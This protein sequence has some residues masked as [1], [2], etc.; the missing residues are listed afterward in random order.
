MSLR[1]NE[2]AGKR[3]GILIWGDDGAGEEGNDTGSTIRGRRTAAGAGSDDSEKGGEGAYGE[4]SG[5]QEMSVQE[6]MQSFGGG[7]LDGDLPRRSNKSQREPSAATSAGGS[8]VKRGTRRMRARGTIKRNS[9]FFDATLPN[10]LVD[11]SASEGTLDEARQD[12]DVAAPTSPSTLPTT[13]PLDA[14]LLDEPPPMMAGVVEEE[15][16]G[17]SEDDEDDPNLLDLPASPL[18]ALSL[19][20][21]S[22]ES[23]FGELSFEGGVDLC[24]EVEDLGGGWSLGF[25]KSAGEQGRGLI[26]RGWYAYVDKPKPLDDETEA[27]ETHERP[28][29]EASATFSIATSDPTIALFFPVVLEASETTS[30]ADP[31][32]AVSSPLNASSPPAHATSSPPLVAPSLPSTPSTPGDRVSIHPSKPVLSP[33]TPPSNTTSLNP[34]NASL[35]P[36][37]PLSLPPPF[38]P[39]SSALPVRSPTPPSPSPTQ[40]RSPNFP[41]PTPPSPISQP[42]T[43]LLALPSFPQTPISPTASES[44]VSEV[45]ESPSVIRARSIGRHVIISGIEFEPT[46]SE[47]AL[48]EESEEV[49]QEG[50]LSLTEA[51]E[52]AGERIPFDGTRPFGEVAEVENFSRVHRSGEEIDEHAEAEEGR[53]ERWAKAVQDAD[54]RASGHDGRFDVFEP[55]GAKVGSE[56]HDV[57]L[58]ESLFEEQG[59]YREESY[60][61]AEDVD[62][63][64]DLPRRMEVV[65]PRYLTSTE[66][67]PSPTP[68]PSSFFDL[69]GLGTIGRSGSAGSMIGVKGA[70]GRVGSSVGASERVKGNVSVEEWVLNGDESHEEEGERRWHIESGPAWLSDSEAFVVHV[71][72]PCKRS[73]YNNRAYT[74][75]T[76]TTVF[77]SGEDPITVERRYSHFVQLHALLSSRYPLIVIPPL[78][79]KT[80]AGRFEDGFVE[81]RRRD[82]ERW[83]GRVGRHPVLR[84]SDEIKEFL[85]L[86]GD[87]DLKRLLN[88]PKDD[89]TQGFFGRV[90]HPA[91]NVDAADAEELGEIFDSHTRAVELGGGFKTVEE[92]VF[93]LR[94]GL[95]DTAGTLKTLAH[96]LARLV[97]GLALPP[98]TAA[99]QDDNDVEPPERERRRARALGLQNE[100]GAMTWKYGCEESLSTAKALQATAES[101]ASVADLVDTHARD[102]LL[103]TQELLREISYPSSQHAA[104]IQ[105]HKSAL[106]LHKQLTASDANDEEAVSRCDTIINITSAELERAHAERNEDM[107]MVAEQYLDGE[108]AFHEQALAK[109][110]FARSHFEPSAFASLALTGPRLR[111]TLER[112]S[113]SFPNLPVPSSYGMP[114]STLGVGS[115]IGRPGAVVSEVIGS[116]L[117]RSTTPVVHAYAERA[118]ATSGTMGRSAAEILAEA[119]HSRPPPGQAT[120]RSSIF[121]TPKLW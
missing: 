61:E 96:H 106:A 38:I 33:E 78:P 82:L 118:S 64:P 46:E 86:E 110:R 100:D 9:I 12:V 8:T 20:P 58:N 44:N 87:Q 23:A 68:R 36:F 91:F 18:L 69:I 45:S 120:W 37:S 73:S 32:P 109:L 19:H 7:E 77:A 85:S 27:A 41:L 11:P 89:A 40:T 102:A 104:L 101:I 42:S 39:A 52:A 13:S 114:L 24:V 65:P 93:K 4:T 81:S 2:E 115:S 92:D 66:E 49:E 90:F 53:E 83:S 28:T 71:H 95:R 29:S 48:M 15:A 108:I 76:L 97:A 63:V 72:S 22:G 75:F 26:P 1:R 99:E 60:P 74:S 56:E 21:F 50:E 10:P 62:Q 80:Y 35:F 98:V 88:P 34:P 55:E 84:S 17:G 107:R 57:H 51:A 79:P 67:E 105:S 3:A 54:L 103:P 121:G 111:S 94:S 112:Q 59:D 14:S 25:I 47:A 30:S 43:S 70:G 116:A 113:S 117:G 6:L 16:E 31:S 119:G 5:E